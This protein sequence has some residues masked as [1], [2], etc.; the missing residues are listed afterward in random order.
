M[1][2]F[3]EL[4]KKTPPA[5]VTNDQ[6]EA[7]QALIVFFEYLGGLDLTPLF[8]LEDELEKA[9]QENNAGEYDGNEIATDASDGRLFMYG[10]DADRLLEIAKPILEKSDIIK[11]VVATLRYR[12]AEEGT[13]EREVKLGSDPA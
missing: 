8:E 5:E 1:N 9:I 2:F 10:P 13:R 4:F 7:E 11:N 3:S 12:P 6:N